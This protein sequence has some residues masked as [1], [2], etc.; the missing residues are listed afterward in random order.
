MDLKTVLTEVRA[1]PIEERL[2]LVEEVWDGL[3]KESRSTDAGDELK[4][5]LDRRLESLEQKPDAVIPWEAVEERA[6]NRF[7]R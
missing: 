6:H 1:W 4:L 2:R 5:L 3:C 7:R